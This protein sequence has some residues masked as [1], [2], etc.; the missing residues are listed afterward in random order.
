MAEAQRPH[1]P[2]QPTTT[3]TINT[4]DRFRQSNIIMSHTRTERD[5]PGEAADT[6]QFLHVP[7]ADQGVGTS[8]G[9]VFPRGVKLDADAV[10]RVSVDGLDGLQLRITANKHISAPNH[11]TTDASTETDKLQEPE[12]NL[13]TRCV[14]FNLLNVQERE[15]QMCCIQDNG[16]PNKFKRKAPFT[17]VVL[18]FGNH[19]VV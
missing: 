18:S 10:G 17:W 9:E 3:S 15:A 8:C 11:P 4:K 13:H 2:V 7:Q 1:R 14:C 12:N 16:L 5:W 6:H 19:A